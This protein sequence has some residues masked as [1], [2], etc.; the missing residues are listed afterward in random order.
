MCFDISNVHQSIIVWIC[1]VAPGMHRKGEQGVEVR[2][3]LGILGVELQ[4]FLRTPRFSGF[5]IFK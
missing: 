3:D 5:F 1:C 2:E 4:R